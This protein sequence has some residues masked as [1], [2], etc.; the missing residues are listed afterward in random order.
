MTPWRFTWFHLAAFF[1]WPVSMTW[2]SRGPNGDLVGGTDP[3]N[4]KT[5]QAALPESVRS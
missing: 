2:E 1:G 4:I 3:G 5:V